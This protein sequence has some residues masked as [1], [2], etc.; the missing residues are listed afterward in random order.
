MTAAP[1]NARVVV[2]GDV[3]TDVV[4]LPAGPIRPGTDTP[5]RIRLT[6]GG[7]A[8]NTAAWLA[9][10]GTPVTLVATVGDDESGRARL[11]ELAA[12]GVTCAVR[13]CPGRP[14]GI[15]VVLAAEGDRAMLTDRGATL[16]LTA[17]DIDA[18]LTPDATHLH[19]SAYPLFAPRTRRAARHALAAAT[20]RGLTTSVDAASAGPLR[21]VGPPAFLRWVRGTD[22]LLANAD[23]A[24]TL[25]GTSD[26]R[27]AARRL[28]EIAAVAVVKLG[29]GGAVWADREGTLLHAPADPVDLVD[30]TGAGDAFAAGLL[31]AWLGGAGAAA[32]LRA[33][34]HLGRT[35]VTHP[36]AR[37]VSFP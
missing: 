1:V 23:E 27:D 5:A 37:P 15:I 26:A 32:A 36:G 2:V 30:P 25:T 29:P 35:A 17:A 22:L 7:Q 8:A 24:E 9:G 16:A 12:L 31:A 33:G 34:T 6:G 3:M 21:R 14:T 4:A 10:Q 20:D 19:L 11:A 18:A 13:S 28:T